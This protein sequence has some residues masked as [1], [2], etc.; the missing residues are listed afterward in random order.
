MQNEYLGHRSQEN[1][2]L[3]E[4]HNYCR[5]RM[6]LEAIFKGESH[7][8]QWLI[9]GQNKWTGLLL[10]FFCSVVQ[11]LFAHKNNPFY[12]FQYLPLG[13]LLFKIQ[14]S[15]NL[16]LNQNTIMFN[17]SANRLMWAQLICKQM[18]EL[19]FSGFMCFWI[20]LLWLLKP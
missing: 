18:L 17:Q 2:L 12:L 10:P 8:I 14:L 16:N 20:L 3:S 13:S 9:K 7:I 4:I 6:T 1:H 15:W 19:H 5:T 11:S